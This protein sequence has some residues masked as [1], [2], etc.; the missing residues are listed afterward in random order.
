MHGSTHTWGWSGWMHMLTSTPLSPLSLGASMDSLSHF[1]Y[2]SFKIKWVS[3]LYP[4]WQPQNI[5][6]LCWCEILSHLLQMQIF[7]IRIQG[8]CVLLCAYT[9]TPKYHKHMETQI[10]THLETPVRKSFSLCLHPRGLHRELHTAADWL[11]EGVVAEAEPSLWEP[12]WAPGAAASCIP[13]MLLL[14][15]LALPCFDNLGGWQGLFLCDLS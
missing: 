6:H 10:Q 1:C 3:W 11:M 8:K 13:H 5:A 12:S 7:S 2:G 15:G 4:T 14:L 9:C